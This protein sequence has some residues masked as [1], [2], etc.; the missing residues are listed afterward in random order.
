[1][2]RTA[3]Q[4]RI[5]GLYMSTALKLR[6]SVLLQYFCPLPPKVWLMDQQ[7]TG[8][9][10]VLNHGLHLNLPEPFVNVLTFVTPRS[11]RKM[12]L[13]VGCSRES[14]GHRTCGSHAQ[15]SGGTGLRGSLKWFWCAVKCK[16]C[17][18]QI[19]FIRATQSVVPGPLAS[20]PPGNFLEMQTLT[21]IPFLIRD[22]GVGPT[23]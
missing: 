7:L 19:Q 2:H 15:T 1:M 21:F 4:Q 17:C 9:F 23:G 14:P 22:S 8:P 11:L 3:P 6:Y 13:K 12:V 10:P 20:A 5:T 16:S 18:L